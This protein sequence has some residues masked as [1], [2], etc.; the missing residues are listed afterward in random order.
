MTLGAFCQAGKPYR[1]G[2]FLF[3][4]FQET[5]AGLFA[6]G[7][8]RRKE[9]WTMGKL[10]PLFLNQTLNTVQVAFKFGSN[11]SPQEKSAGDEYRLRRK[12]RKVNGCLEGIA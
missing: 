12:E 5:D 3:W 2:K 1:R 10:S 4:R 6:L 11:S 8:R 7:T 9:F